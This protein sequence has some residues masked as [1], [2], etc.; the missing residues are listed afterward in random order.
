MLK[1]S[2]EYVSLHFNP[3]LYIRPQLTVVNTHQLTIFL[4]L[5][6]FGTEPLLGNIFEYGLWGTSFWYNIRQTDRSLGSVRSTVK[7]LRNVPF[8][9]SFKLNAAYFGRKGQL[10]TIFCKKL[11]A[12]LAD[13]YTLTRTVPPY[14]HG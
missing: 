2:L 13:F 4:K 6:Y 3:N 14:F 8:F 9:L 12:T 1:C 7:G 10:K 11:D 5:Y